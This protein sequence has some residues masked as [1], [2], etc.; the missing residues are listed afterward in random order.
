MQDQF[1]R[2]IRYLRLSVTDLCNLRCQYCMPEAGVEKKSHSALMTEDEMMLAVKVAAGLGV[3]KVRV[4]GGEPLVKPNIV[5]IV[6]R[7]AQTPGIE[8]VCLTTN[9][10][11]LPSM[12]RDL[13]QAGLK[14]VNISLDSL[15]PQTYAMLTRG[16]RVEEAWKGVESALAVGFDKVKI[17]AVLIGGVNDHEVEALAGLTRRYPVDV[18]FIELMPMVDNPHFDDRS[19][20]PVRTVLDRLPDLRALPH[21]GSVARRFRLPGALGDV[22]LISPVSEHFCTACNRIR[23]TAD[24][25]LKPCLHFAA[26]ENIKGLNETDMRAVMERVMYFK[27]ACH[28]TLSHEEHSK[29]GRSMA[30]IGG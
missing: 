14:R 9:A 7:I 1:G 2:K 13:K 12:A 22:G 10:V 21:D 4:T 23:L 3:N 15:N 5:S 24:G 29:A 16:G 17:N 28:D 6:R 8:E 25:K 30:Q 26:E 11:L 27:P 19:Y 18:R 20:V